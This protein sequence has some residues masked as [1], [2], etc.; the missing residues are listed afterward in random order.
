MTWED[1]NFKKRSVTKYTKKTKD[2][3]YKPVSVKMNDELHGVLW[4]MWNNR[5][6][7][8]W[9]FYNEKYDNRFQH[10]P[11]FMKG[12]C[13]RAGIVP[14]FTFHKLRHLMSSLLNDDPK[15]ATKTIQSILGHAEQR[16][17]EI[18][19]HELPGGVE[20]AMDSIS[21]KFMPKEQNVPPESA[22]RNEKG[23]H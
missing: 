18:Y 2:G 9:L 23:P 15:V 21:G 22:T 13:K 12:L 3:S 16:T 19:L 7:N 14:Y 8:T 4:Q 1:I 6:Q 17:T 20:D 5:K 10:R 11:K